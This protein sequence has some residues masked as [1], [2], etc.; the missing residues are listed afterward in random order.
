M[1]NYYLHTSNIGVF[2]IDLVNL[3]ISQKI[4]LY[5][6]HTG[7]NTPSIQNSDEYI[8]KISTIVTQ[9]TYYNDTLTKSWVYQYVSIQVKIHLKKK[10]RSRR[11]IEK[12]YKT[13]FFIVNV[14]Q[15][16]TLLLSCLKF[17]SAFKNLN[18]RT[19]IHM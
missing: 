3:L 5:V 8:Y 16:R 12:P 14:F 10:T 17:V 1:N 11:T 13:V 6:Y 9:K 18:N 19:Y 7:N 15:K 2:E 4:L